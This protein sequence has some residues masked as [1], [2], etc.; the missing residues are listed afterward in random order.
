M[1]Q[2]RTPVPSSTCGNSYTH[3]TGGCKLTT[4][5]CDR[6]WSALNFKSLV[7]EAQVPPQSASPVPTAVNTAVSVISS[8]FDPHGSYI[9]GTDPGIKINI[10]QTLPSYTIPGPPVFSCSGNSDPAPSSSAPVVSSSS[11]AP[12]PSSTSAAPPA[13]SSASGAGTAQEYAQCGGTLI[14]DS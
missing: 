4:V 9:P 11:A 10:Y 13:S 3:M 8:Y 14:L 2:T 1:P 12:E 6:R 7:V 5:P